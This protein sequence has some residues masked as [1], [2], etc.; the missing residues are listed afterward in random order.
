MQSDWKREATGRS[1]VTKKVER[2]GG[3]GI[4]IV[5]SKFQ[6]ITWAIYLER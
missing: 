5:A 2:I 6:S 3:F 1:T 4:G